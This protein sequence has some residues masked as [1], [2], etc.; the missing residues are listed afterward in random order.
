MAIAEALARGLPVISTPTGAIP[1]LIGA[2]QPDAAGLLVNAGDVEA[3]ASALRMVIQEPATRAR[4]AAGAR[5]ARERLCTWE[6][7]AGQMDEA[8]RGFQR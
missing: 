8:L 2:G 3:L 7:M 4:L 5:G 6:D 1:D